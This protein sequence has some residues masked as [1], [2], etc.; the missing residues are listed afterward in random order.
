MNAPNP[1]VQTEPGPAGDPLQARLI[2]E[3]LA[4]EMDKG[5]YSLASYDSLGEAVKYGSGCMKLFWDRK[6]DTRMRRTPV[7]QSPQEVLAEA[8]EEALMGQ[9]PM[10][11]PRL[12]GFDLMPQQALIRNNICYRYVHIRDVFPEPN[13]TT[14]DKVIHREKVAYGDIVRGIQD[15]VFFDV[16]EQIDNMIEGEKFESDIQAIKYD[17]G[18]FDV[19]RS[20]AKFEKKHTVWELWSDLP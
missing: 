17:R 15:N 1:P 20:V 6:V 5:K 19:N 16:R 11:E 8:P 13:T 12:K 4:Y 14:W 18:Y 9:A 10:P 2:Q 3:I 7:E